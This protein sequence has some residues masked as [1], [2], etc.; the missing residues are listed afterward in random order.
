[1][2]DSVLNR[3]ETTV[4]G[5]LAAFVRTEILDKKGWSS[6]RLAEEINLAPATV[7]N[8][9]NGTTKEPTLSVIKKLAKVA[10]RPAYKLLMLVD[11]DIEIE[12]TQLVNQ[13]T[14]TYPDV[15][16]ELID[17]MARL[18]RLASLSPGVD[19]DLLSEVETKE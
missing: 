15:D 16:P 7:T 2:S 13:L 12:L 10:R 14:S 3:N 17:I 11:H 8:I 9:V 18:K 5:K 19:D 4:S 1:M 6:R